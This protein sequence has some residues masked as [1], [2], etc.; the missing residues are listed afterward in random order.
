M[1]GGSGA[2]RPAP[3]PTIL[4]SLLL[5]GQIAVT[6]RSADGGW[7][8]VSTPALQIRVQAV[9]DRL[10]PGAALFYFDSDWKEA[11]WSRYWVWEMYPTRVV[12][13]PNAASI[14]D[15][16]APA[17][18]PGRRRFLLCRAPAPKGIHFRWSIVLPP[19]PEDRRTLVLGE[20]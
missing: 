17:G 6:I 13:V 2:P 11:W 3:L 12:R 10:P 5:A 1:T 19:I 20:F 4:L 8:F 14:Q 7:R 15:L 9:R 18:T 16:L